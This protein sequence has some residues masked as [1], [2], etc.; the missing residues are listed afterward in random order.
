MIEKHDAIWMDVEEDNCG[1]IVSEDY[2]PELGK[3]F[4]VYERRDGGFMPFSYVK[5]H[6]PQYSLPIWN[7]ENT[8]VLVASLDEAKHYLESYGA[9]T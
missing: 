8:K 1:E 6:G 3:L 2:S 5:Q 9:N 7:N 4:V